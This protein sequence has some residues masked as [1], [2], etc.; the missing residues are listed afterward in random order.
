VILVPFKALRRAKERPDG[1]TD[2]ADHLD[3]RII[4]HLPLKDLQR[5]RAMWVPHEKMAVAALEAQQPA[6]LTAPSN[7]KKSQ[8]K[9]KSPPPPQGPRHPVLAVLL[10][11]LHLCISLKEHWILWLS[12]L[13]AANSLLGIAAPRWSGA[14]K[15]L[16]TCESPTDTP[17]QDCYAQ[18]VGN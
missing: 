3:T 1:L 10:R 8:R 2:L 17:F 13:S 7:Q 5:I 14:A 15:C 18:A 11:G 4:Q 6:R 12:M 16:C 9:P